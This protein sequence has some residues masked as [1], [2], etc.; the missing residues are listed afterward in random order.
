MRRVQIGDIL[1]LAGAIAG[2]PLPMAH[3][4]RLCDEAHAAHIHMK[5]LSR[6]HP[7]W[8]N[9]SLMSRIYADGIAMQADWSPQGV[10][11]LGLACEALTHWRVERFHCHAP[12]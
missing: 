9:G 8:G 10:A 5:R 6:L 7:E 4:L 12:R 2:R 11:A 3:A 1:A